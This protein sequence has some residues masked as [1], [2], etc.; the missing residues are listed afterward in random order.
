[1]AIRIIADSG[2]DIT[3]EEA[4]ELGIEILPIKTIFGE[5]EY[6][7]GI[8]LTHEEFFEKLIESDIFPTT[9]Q[10]SP[11]EYEQKY[12]EIKKDG[13]R[14][15]VITLSSKLSGCFQ[16]AN[17]AAEDYEGIVFPVD[18]LSVTAG[19]RILIEYAVRLRE[20]G[21]QIQEIIEKLEERKH[22]IRLIALLDTLEYLKKGGRI[23]A[24]AAMAG[25]LLSIKPVVAIE[26]GEVT[27]LGKARGSKA[28]NNML[29]EMV[30]KE[31]II[32]FS[33]P[34]ALVY[35]GL[36]D[37]LLQK[38][39]KD[40]RDLFEDAVGDIQGYSLGCAIG[41][42]IGPGAIGTAFFVE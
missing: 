23:S 15:I 26:N 4:R 20:Q 13:D 29:R 39:K 10:I 18:S 7:D 12:E 28:G 3:Q 31:G 32:D 8:D 22:K 16:S 33:M 35:S 40:N 5:T 1:M 9:S 17:I 38:Y 11:F 6:R 41:T 27:V 24:A 25:A 42:H 34:F 30:N 2:C 36:S 14:A 21:L 19:E 37:E